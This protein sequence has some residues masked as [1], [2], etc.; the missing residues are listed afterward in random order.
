MVHNKW[1]ALDS[2]NYNTVVGYTIV[3]REFIWGIQCWR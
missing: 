3:M 2:R 1:A